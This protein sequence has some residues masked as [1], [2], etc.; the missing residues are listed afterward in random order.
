MRLGTQ[1][2]GPSTLGDAQVQPAGQPKP[3][4]VRAQLWLSRQAFC[5]VAQQVDP[6]TWFAQQ[7]PFWQV[8]PAPQV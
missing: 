6:H 3:L 8:S 7:I 1:S 2:L 5:P 4:Q